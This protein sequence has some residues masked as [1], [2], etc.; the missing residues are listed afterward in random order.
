MRLNEIFETH[1]SAVRA[2]CRDF[3]AVFVK[4]QGTRLWDERGHEYLDFFSGAGALNYGHNPGTIK[5]RLLEYVAAD[6][7]THS[8]DLYTEAKARF[9]EAL[10]QII[11]K[12]RNL[13]YVVQFTG[14]TGTNS[15]EAALKLARKITGRT[16]II[17]FTNSFH[18]MSLG[19]LSVTASAFKRAAAGTPLIEALHM[20]FDGYFGDTVDTAAYIE[21]LLDDPG[22]GIALPAAFIVETIQAEGGINVASIQWLQR[23]RR[24]ASERG[25]LLIVDD[26][27]AGCGR[28]GPFFSFEEAALYPDM[29]CLSKSI[30]GY[31]LPLALLLIRPELD[32]WSPGEHN[33]TFRGNNLAFVTATAALNFWIDQ[34]FEHEIMRK[35]HLMRAELARICG[36]SA[37]IKGRGML[38]GLTWADRQTA[39]AISLGAFDKGLIAETCGQ[40]QHVLKLIPPLTITDEDLMA[41]LNILADT[42]KDVRQANGKSPVPAMSVA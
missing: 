21:K 28:T 16:T 20:P 34:G 42:I 12:P 31:G 8:L 7:I 5:R 33:G 26:I 39:K 36:N 25:I 40:Y 2:Y 38:V 22:S 23:L 11:L 1:E 3:S 4:A 17:A 35:G 14:P 29:V 18:G 15:V 24:I 9:L 6:G 41:G 32:K 19:S 13:R 10:N 30:S 37:E 27:Q